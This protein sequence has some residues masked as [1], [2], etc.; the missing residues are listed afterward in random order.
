MYLQFVINSAK[1]LEIN[2]K[3]QSKIKLPTLARLP[4]TKNIKVKTLVFLTVLNI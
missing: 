2:N 3:T 1:I 4:K